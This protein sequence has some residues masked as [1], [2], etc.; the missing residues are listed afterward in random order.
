MLFFILYLIFSRFIYI[1]D[2][3][4]ARTN[5]FKY[6]NVIQSSLVQVEQYPKRYQSILKNVYN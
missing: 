4:F 3:Q 5:V 1:T 6:F 2:N